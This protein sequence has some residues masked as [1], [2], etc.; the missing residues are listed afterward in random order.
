MKALQGVKELG[1]RLLKEA[2]SDNTHK[3]EKTA[4]KQFGDF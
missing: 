2:W 4:A 3:Q 1:E